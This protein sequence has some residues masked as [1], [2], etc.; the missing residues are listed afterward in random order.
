MG[1]S[2]MSFLEKSG[3]YYAVTVS[4]QYSVAQYMWYMHK[5]GRQQL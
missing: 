1:Q 3:L 2:F 5:A 4:L